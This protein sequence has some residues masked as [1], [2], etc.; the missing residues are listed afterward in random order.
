MGKCNYCKSIDSPRFLLD[1]NQKFVTYKDGKH[2]YLMTFW[3][4]AEVDKWLAKNNMQLA[5]MHN[6]NGCRQVYKYQLYNYEQARCLRISYIK[7]FPCNNQ[8]CFQKREQLRLLT[9]KRYLDGWYN[10]QF[11][12]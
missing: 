4:K 1:E 11:V 8:K 12:V 10:I 7:E 5:H 6:P 3:S 2:I 9:E